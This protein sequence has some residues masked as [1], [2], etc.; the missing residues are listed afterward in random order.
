[1][2]TG[3]KRKRKREDVAPAWATFTL[4]YNKRATDITKKPTAAHHN[5]RRIIII[6]KKM[7]LLQDVYA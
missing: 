6:K 1:M 7:C 5:T 2:D 3:K 4:L